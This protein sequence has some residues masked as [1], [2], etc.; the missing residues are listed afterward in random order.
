MTLYEECLEAL[1]EGVE[2]LSKKDSEEIFEWFESNFF[3]S[4]GRI[5]WEKSKG[6][7]LINSLEELPK[8]IQNEMVFILWDEADTPVLKANFRTV[9]DVIDD[10]TAVSFDTW[11]VGRDSGYVVEYHHEGDITIAILDL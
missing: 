9:L 1:G 4:Y 6:L 2:I 5:D 8:C 3:I 10:V 7:T 11:L